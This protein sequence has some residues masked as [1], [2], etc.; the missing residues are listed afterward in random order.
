MS[1]NPAP[2]DP[3]SRHTDVQ[4]CSRQEFKRVDLLWPCHER[5]RVV[6]SETVAASRIRSRLNAGQPAIEGRLLAVIAPLAEYASDRRPRVST[7]DV[8][9]DRA[10]ADR[11]TGLRLTPQERAPMCTRSLAAL[12]RTQ[13]EPGCLAAAAAGIGV[14]HRRACRT[15]SRCNWVVLLPMP[16]RA[17][18]AGGRARAPNRVDFSPT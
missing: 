18:Q 4:A 2:T 3:P 1:L 15:P 14:L 13:V 6:L 12:Q 5:I 16:P 7:A 11:P 10:Y 9:L 8:R 17:A